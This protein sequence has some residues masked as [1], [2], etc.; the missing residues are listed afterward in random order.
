MMARRHDQSKDK[1]ARILQLRDQ[2][3]PFKVIAE[4][5]GLSVGRVRDICAA[6]RPVEEPTNAGE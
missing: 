5:V 4:R 6:H 3:I 1:T 2:H